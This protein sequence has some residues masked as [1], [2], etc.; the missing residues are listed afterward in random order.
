[1]FPV[2]KKVARRCH[3]YT[4]MKESAKKRHISFHTPGHKVGKWDIT[5]L[6]YSDTLRS[7]T[8]CIARAEREVAKA[9]GAYASFLLTDGSTAGV[10]S[11]LYAAKRLGVRHIAA[12]DCAHESF[13]H[14]CEIL[15]LTPLLYSMEERAG[16]PFLPSFEDCKGAGAFEGAECIFLT[17]PTYYGQVAE[18]KKYRE[19]CDERGIL[20]LV[21]GA[22]GGHLHFER[23]LYAGSYADMWVD[24][25]HKSLP[26]LTQGAIASA[27]SEN[28]AEVLREGVERFR[29]SSPSYPIMASVEYAALYPR[30]ACLEKEVRAYQAQEERVLFYEDW[31]KLCVRF[32][33]HA[34]QAQKELEAKGIYPEFCD[35]EWVVFYLSPAT[36]TRR[37]RL[38]KRALKALFI[39]YPYEEEKH[40]QRNP[41]PLLS[42]QNGEKE[43]VEIEQ[44]AGRICAQNCGL[45][46][47]CTPLLR[48]GEQIDEKKIA[49]LQAA[50]NLFGVREGKLLV[51]RQ[52]EEA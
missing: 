24:G 46:P 1:M 42:L 20:L 43:W 23:E 22:H 8:G 33:K 39:K 12:A 2:K 14:G 16:A 28:F 36:K 29:T 15:G 37:F 25:V 47:P 48:A 45:F 51:Y 18:L 4:M 26:A 50:P 40:V 44:A 17:S 32:G 21:D 35:G 7:P 5:E 31:S 27:R 41:A 49:A 10:L 34:F 30:N 52:E 19:Y 38:L 3:I 11:M 6:S 13:L 9:L